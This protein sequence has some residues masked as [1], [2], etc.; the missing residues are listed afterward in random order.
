MDSFSIPLHFN[1][2]R[3]K[4]DAGKTK[5]SSLTT[6]IEQLLLVEPRWLD[7]T[8]QCVESIVNGAKS[9]IA[10][11]LGSIETGKW[12]DIEL[13]VVGDSIFAK[14]DGKE[15]FSIKLKA[16]TLPGIFSTATLDEQTGEVILKIA[17]TSTEHTTAK[18]NLQGKGNQE[19]QAHPPF[20]QER[21]GVRTPLTI[22]TNILSWVENPYVT[23]E[24]N[25]ATVE[26]PASL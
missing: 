8:Q 6:R 4:K 21:P 23:T 2:M 17:N 24:K 3:A 11:T 14:L 18:I 13:K 7:N 19:W 26:I 25:G 15:I 5:A 16:N 20:C 12:Y 10:T 9:Q 1:H 22:P